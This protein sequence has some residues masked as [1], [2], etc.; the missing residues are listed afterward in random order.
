MLEE[1][2]DAGVQAV[3]IGEKIDHRALSQRGYH[4]LLGH[5]KVKLDAIVKDAV[6][7]SAVHFEVI[8]QAELDSVGDVLFSYA[9]LDRQQIL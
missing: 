1:L 4:L 9:R 8:L 3:S 6:N 2:T 7:I 5:S